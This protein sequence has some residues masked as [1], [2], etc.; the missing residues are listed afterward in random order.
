M[1]SSPEVGA[2][3]AGSYRLTAEIASGG[4]GSV[5]RATNINLDAPVAVKFMHVD[6]VEDQQLRARFEREAK[7]S[8]R[9]R[10]PHVVRV[11]DHGVDELTGMPF[12][13][14]EALEGE[15]LGRRLKRVGKLE[16]AEVIR[17]AEQI[18]RGLR[19]AHDLG[20]VHRDLKPANV[21]LCERDDDMVKLLD[22]GIAKL[23][24]S[25]SET[26]P[27]ARGLG[28]EPESLTNTG[29]ILGSPHYMSPEQIRA[30]DVDARSDLWSLAVI[31]Y[32]ALTGRRPFEARDI[33]AVFVAI[34]ADPLDPPSRIAP[35][36]PTS[37]DRFF[38]KALNRDPDGRYGNATY[39]ARAFAEAFATTAHAQ[40]TAAAARMSTTA[41]ASPSSP[42]APTSLP[43]MDRPPRTL[44]DGPVIER[45]TI[46]PSSK[47][48][49][50]HVAS[51][52]AGAA[53]LAAAWF[54]IDPSTI[55]AAQRVVLD[56][57]ERLSE[58]AGDR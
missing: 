9:I 51:L 49:L 53:I 46:E 30:T 28:A 47:S 44:H 25:G 7:A 27:A 55:E 19:R 17:V 57:L 13:V 5:W 37:I 2:L 14:M 50:R 36:L 45:E 10:S 12:I 15:D 32:R 23:A 3:I 34:C 33:S 16:P 31:L 48:P 20:V 38:A 58:M 54:L 22:F 35:S 24:G 39:F 43:V 41:V 18:C 21:F 8:A 11:H 42:A 4:M 1:M 40:P 6:M 56:T 26:T 52:V 29:Q